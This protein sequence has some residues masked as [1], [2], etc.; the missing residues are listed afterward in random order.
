MKR[1]VLLIGAGG[2]AKNVIECIDKEKY[3]IIGILDKDEDHIHESVN[4]IEIIGTDKNIQYYYDNGVDCAVIAIGHMGM[5]FVRD[6]I[7]RKLKEVG[8]DL[9]NVQHPTGYI[10]PSAELKDGIVIMP[11][12]IVNA[13]ARIGSN[14]ILNTRSIIEHE[15]V[16]ENNVHIAPGTV[17]AGAAIIGK[18]SFIGAGSTVIQ[19]I[20]IGRNVIIGAGSVIIRDV[21]DNTKVVGIPGRELKENI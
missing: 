18:N 8:F 13:E 6:R 20:T 17:I 1:N 19:G 11:G 21:P 16:V 3:S 14:V 12:V 10:S 5:P 4:G 2:H 7:Y 9:I 15:V